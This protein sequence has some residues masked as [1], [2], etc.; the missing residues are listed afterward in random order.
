MAINLSHKIERIKPSATLSVANRAAELKAAGQDIID[1]S[2]GEPDFDIPTFVKEAAIEALQRGFTKYTAVDG[3]TPLKE[4]I[5]NK[6]CRENQLSYEKDQII[7]SSGAKQSLS[8]LFTALLNPGDE[9]IVPAPYWVSYPDMV[10]LADGLPVTLRTQID[11]RFKISPAQLE[12]AITP[13][14]RLLILNSP[15]NPSGMVYSREELKELGQVLNQHPKVMVVTDDIY[16]HILFCD[17]PFANIVNACPELYDRTMVINGVSKAYAM[18]GFRIGYTAGPKAVI[19]AMKKVQS[20]TTSNPCS[21][22][23]YA[24]LAAL[25]GDQT[26]VQVMAQEFKRRHDFFNTELNKIPGLTCLPCDGAFYCFVYIEQLLHEDGIKTDLE[27][28][29]YLLKEAQ[30]ATVPGSAFGTPGYLRL[31]F[32]TDMASL[33]TAVARIQTAISRLHALNCNSHS[34]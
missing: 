10:L 34:V 18:T 1:L 30:V 4:A 20:Q 24:A 32:A 14:T 21:I 7:V 2:I 5:I 9:V 29:D 3:I 8:N 28:A 27:F 13:Q 6:F 33:Q 15:S 11:Q 12:G 17:Q 26:C 31:S 16:E 25:T 19:A 22:S 23:Q